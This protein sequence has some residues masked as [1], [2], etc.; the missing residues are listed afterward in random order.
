[1][2][3]EK[4]I[5]FD[6]TDNLSQL[7]LLLEA[8]RLHAAAADLVQDRHQVFAFRGGLAQFCEP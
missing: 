2:Q 3:P 1:M 5:L 8:L 7:E 4:H 6:P